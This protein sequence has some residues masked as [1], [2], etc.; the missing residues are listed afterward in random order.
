[1]TPGVLLGCRVT[2]PGDG[3]AFPLEG[4]LDRREKFSRPPL[5]LLTRSARRQAG[6]WGIPTAGGESKGPARNSSPSAFVRAWRGN[7][8]CARNR[9]LIWW[10][11][12]RWQGEKTRNEQDDSRF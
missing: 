12:R 6:R 4:W 1:V 7:L 10:K 3:V 11:W 8:A 5:C 2:R 9:R